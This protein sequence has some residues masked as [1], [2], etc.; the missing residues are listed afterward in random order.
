MKHISAP[1][2]LI[3]FRMIE[4]YSK[5]LQKSQLKKLIINSYHNA[6]LSAEEVAILV[7][8]YNLRGE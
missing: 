4:N 5:N 6:A 1:I 8:Q 7:A 2:N 3:K